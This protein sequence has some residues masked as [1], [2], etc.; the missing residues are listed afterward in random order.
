MARADVL[1]AYR[2]REEFD[3]CEDFNLWARLSLPITSSP[4]YLRSWCVVECMLVSLPKKRPLAHKSDDWL[5]MQRNS[6]SLGV[7][8]TDTDLKRHLHCRSMR[9]TGVQ[10]RSHLP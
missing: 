7:S 8:F 2:H 3:V 5:S 4:L 6:T 9:E 10:A 1:R